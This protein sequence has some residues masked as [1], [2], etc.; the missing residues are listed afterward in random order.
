MATTI[1]AS[2]QVPVSGA[3]GITITEMEVDFG[4]KPTRGTSV[5]VNVSGMVSTNKIQVWLSGNQA[6]GKGTDELTM[7]CISLAA[8]ANTGNFTLFMSSA[9]YVLGKYKI[10]YTYQ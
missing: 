9:T 6:T 7:D 5:T 4:I 1:L 3:G 8:K 2:R 10:Y